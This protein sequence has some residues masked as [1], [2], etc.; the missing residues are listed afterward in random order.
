M[1]MMMMMKGVGVKNI[2]SKK[3]RNVWFSLMTAYWH[4][5]FISIPDSK[6]FKVAQGHKASF[7]LED[8][9]CDT[10]TKQFYNCTNK[11]NQGIS[12]GCADNYKNNIDCQ[13][14]DITDVSNGE[15][16]IRVNVNPTRNVPE[17]DYS[18]N[19]AFCRVKFNSTTVEASDCSI[20]M[21]FITILL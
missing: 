8:S 4:L 19:A 20:G 16:T 12:V 7:C 6:R 15:Y 11:G 14:I 17:S 5:I 9:E 21:L 1:M 3:C 18:N 13:W 2:S 10:G